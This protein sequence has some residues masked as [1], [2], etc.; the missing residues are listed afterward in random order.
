MSTP[1]ERIL[2]RTLRAGIVVSTSLLGLGLLLLLSRPGLPADLLLH[3]GLLV[4]MGTPMARVLLS[5][6]E[7]VRQR[8]WFFA[9]NAFVVLVVLAVT[10]WQAWRG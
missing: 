7:Y 9:A 5:C 1:F 10:I 2:G 4:L 6:A 8:D 3:A